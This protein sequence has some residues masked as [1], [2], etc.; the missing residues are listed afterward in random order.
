[1]AHA[2]IRS[3]T[4]H[5]G[6]CGRVGTAIVLAL[7]AAGVGHISCNDPQMFDME[8]FACY[9]FSRRSD[10]G[11]AKV[12]VLARFLDGRPGLVFQPVVVANESP[13]I[14]RYLKDADVIVSCA[15]R[16]PARLNLERAGIRFRKPVIQACV[17]DGRRRKGG[18]ISI[19]TP[20]ARRSCFGCLFPQPNPRFMRGEILFPTVTSSIGAIAAQRIVDLL[21]SPTPG[22]AADRNVL[23]VDL[24]RCTIDGL[25]VEPRE[26]CPICGGP[27]KK[28]K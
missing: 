13:K 10:L 4:V 15:N 27:G 18:L 9:P 1:M 11:R 16:L 26:G 24:A 25:S 19:W 3:A 2:D 21:V 12:E 28:R 17:F 8:Q 6:G 14:A 23:M 5:I 20:D 22:S 7:H